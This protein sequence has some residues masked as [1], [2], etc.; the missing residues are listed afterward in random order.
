[1][2]RARR[3]ARTG[4]GLAREVVRIDRGVGVN[5]SV[6]ADK[7]K[8]SLRDKGKVDSDQK[9]KMKKN[10]KWP[11]GR[12]G[13]GLT[14]TFTKMSKVQILGGISTSTTTTGQIKDNLV[15][16]LKGKTPQEK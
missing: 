2:K 1:M 11:I 13:S 4:Q 8:S 6:K 10:R 14:K 16:T 7:I 12:G 5:E 3:T 9:K 15:M